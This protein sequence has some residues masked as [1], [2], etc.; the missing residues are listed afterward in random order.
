MT[1]PIDAPDTFPDWFMPWP[2]FE[3]D[4]G[5]AGL[6]VVDYQNYGSNPGCGVARMLVER[7]PEVASYYVPR[8]EAT[9][10]CARVL[11]DAFRAAGREV[12]YTRHG[13]LLPDGRDLVARRRRR[14]R[15]SVQST[16]RPTLWA[17]GSFEHEVVA[18]LAPREGELVIDKNASSPFN[19]TGVDQLLRNLGLETLVLVGMATDMCVET[20]ARDAADRGFNVV[21]VED[22]VAT[23]YERH[24]VAALSAIARI[25]GQVWD[26][27]RVLREIG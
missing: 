19:G 27:G 10:A 14:D 23:F 25:Y 16:E 2:S 1:T 13:P 7:F 26:S 24:H 22:A 11:L 17:R 3:V 8:I 6:V 9:V 15:D 4:W 21:V 20:T 12:V 5:R 18:A